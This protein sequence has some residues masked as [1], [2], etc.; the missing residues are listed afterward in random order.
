MKITDLEL[1]SLVGPP[2]PVPMK[3]A[4]VPGLSLSRRGAVIVKVHTD[5]GIVGLGT[6]G[7]TTLEIFNR[8]MRT[9]RSSRGRRSTRPARSGPRCERFRPRA[10][11]SALGCTG[12]KSRWI[13][14]TLPV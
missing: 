7:Y 5:E 9:R 13:G 11:S 1:I 8:L 3:P 10:S 6:P 14:T 4:W 2:L 12:S